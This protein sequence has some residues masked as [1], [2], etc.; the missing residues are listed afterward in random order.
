LIFMSSQIVPCVG[1]AIIDE[2]ERVLL[3]KHV[4]EKGGFWAGK[5][6]CPGGRLEFGEPLE[7]GVR[8][9]VLEETGLEIDILRWLPPM[10]RIIR[11]PEGTIE[12]HVLYLDVVARVRSG[13]FVPQS[14][15]GEGQWVAIEK[16]PELL[17][18]IHED[19]A[20]L[21]RQAGMLP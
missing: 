6:I 14:D 19:T 15:V 7:A 1:A 9:E 8:R 12:D 5:Y 2:A 11:T 16:L 18:E 13:T 20:T 3:V 4:P 17:D 21:L 10:E